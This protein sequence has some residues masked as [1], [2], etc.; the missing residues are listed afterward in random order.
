MQLKTSSSNGVFKHYSMIFCAVVGSLMLAPIAQA[1]TL[2]QAVA[3]ALDNNPDLR[4]AL[5]RFK[6][7]EERINQAKS[8]YLPTVDLAAGY[9]YEE[10]NSPSTRRGIYA[11][12]G[13]KGKA[14]LTRGE[15]N[16]SIKQIL[17]DGFFTINDAARTEREASAEQWTLFS[18]AEDLALD[19]A[20]VYNE[21]LKNQEVLSLSEKNLRSHQNIYEQIK[22]R[23]ESGLGSIADLSQVTGRLAR[24]NVNLISATNNYRD[25]VAKFTKLVNQPPNELIVPVP[26]ANMVPSTK[27]LGLALALEM[28]PVIKSSS[29]DIEAARYA[30]ET[31]TSSYYPTFTL[32]VTANANDNISGEEGIDRFKNDIG[33]HNNSAQAMVRMKYNLYSGGR[34]ASQTREAAYQI[35]EAVELNRKAHRDV[36]EGYSLAWNAHELLT[37]Q[38]QFIQQH[39]DSSK[40]TQAAYEQQF[41]LGQRS[42]LDLL[43]T[44]NELFEARKDYL[45]A[46]YQN[47]DAKY[48]LLNATGQLLDSLRVTRSSLWY[49]EESYEGGVRP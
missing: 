41:R 49:G 46:S 30:R 45:N 21:V 29:N 4:V 18:T 19:V 24:A 14:S 2:E 16:L 9:G 36:T 22:E 11:T 26:D 28:H 31:F 20:K 23:T 40:K 8:G 38:L 7:A 44:E 25:S 3:Q 34:N 6:V 39:V 13:D 48:R 32:E 43:D 15:L 33:G 12:N 10:T 35:A 37:M 42:L 47:V 17:F 5:T 27:Q 1:Q